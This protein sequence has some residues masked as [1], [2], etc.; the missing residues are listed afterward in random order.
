MHQC[1]NVYSRCCSIARRL[2]E[3]SKASLRAYNL[4]AEAI[5]DISRVSEASSSMMVWNNC[6][7]ICE[8]LYIVNRGVNNKR[9]CILGP[10]TTHIPEDCDSYGGPEPAVWIGLEYGIKLLYI[11]GDLDLSTLLINEAPYVATV[12]FIHIHSDNVYRLT[13]INKRKHLI[14]TSQICTPHSTLPLGGFTDGDRAVILGMLMNASEI[15]VNGYGGKEEY[16]YKD[17]KRPSWKKEKLY[18]THKIIEVTA[19]S[20]NYKL[21]KL[22]NGYLLTKIK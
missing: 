14:Y 6:W 1:Y 12:L 4:I 15:L 13:T 9:L 18:V 22:D 3:A 7:S 8:S 11:T 2:I 10:N 19:E 16:W 5:Y 17:Y 21:E 20:V